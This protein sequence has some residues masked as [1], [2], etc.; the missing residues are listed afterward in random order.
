MRR[1][2][3]AVSLLAGGCLHRETLPAISVEVDGHSLRV[4]VADDPDERAQGL[5]FRESLGQDRGM[6]FVYPDV[7]TRAFWMENTTVPLSI[8]FIDEH[9]VIFRIRDMR[10]LDRGHTAS[11][12]PARYALEVNQGWFAEQGIAEGAQVEGLPGPSK[13]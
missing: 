7:R 4:E 10:P 12:L 6:L 3:L 2:A 8:A 11:G 13:D 9:G 5:M 1:L